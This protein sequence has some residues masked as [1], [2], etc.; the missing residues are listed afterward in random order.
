[1]VCAAEGNSRALLQEKLGEVGSVTLGSDSRGDTAGGVWDDEED[2][3]VDPDAIPEEFSQLEGRPKSSF[4]FQWDGAGC[5]LDIPLAHGAANT[6]FRGQIANPIQAD[7]TPVVAKESSPLSGKLEVS[8]PG[9]F[10]QEI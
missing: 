4:Q 1:M 6:K 5:R 9:R 8:F 10:L 7:L 2:E 3:E